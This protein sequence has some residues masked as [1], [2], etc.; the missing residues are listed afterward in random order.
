MRPEGIDLSVVSFMATK[1]TD[2][3]LVALAK[4]GDEQAFVELWDRLLPMRNSLRFRHY[5]GHDPDDVDQILMIACWRTLGAYDPAR[6]AKWTTWIWL[7]LSRTVKNLHNKA[8]KT[9]LTANKRDMLDNACSLEAPVGKNSHAYEVLAAGDPCPEDILVKREDIVRVRRLFKWLSPRERDGLEAWIAD[10]QNDHEAIAAG[11][12]ES[13]KVAAKWGV[14]RH[15]SLLYAWNAQKKLSKLLAGQVMQ[16]RRWLEGPKAVAVPKHC[17]CGK[18]H[19]ALGYCESCY[20]LHV[21]KGRKKK[22]ETICQGS[23]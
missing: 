16:K 19:K 3:E 13:D 22:G 17:A 18:P 10:D 12:T 5:N 11:R 1:K 23:A 21:R 9:S 15:C 8:N 4:A 20:Y 6:G 2:E 7:V 14:S